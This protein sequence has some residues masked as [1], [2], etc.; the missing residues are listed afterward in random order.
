[1]ERRNKILS[2]FCAVVTLVNTFAGFLIP[3]TTYAKTTVTDDF[4]GSKILLVDKNT[5]G[6]YLT[7]NGEEIQAK[8][9]VYSAEEVARL[10]LL[11]QSYL[12]QK[13]SLEDKIVKYYPSEIE[14]ISKELEL[15]A[16][17]KKVFEESKKKYGDNF[18]SITI[19]DITYYDKEQAG[20]HLLEEVKK[21]MTTDVTHIGNYRGF[22]L[23]IFF[24][25]F[26]NVHKMNIK[27]KYHYQIEL[28]N[29][30]YGNLTRLENAFGN[31]EKEIDKSTIELSNLKEQLENAKLEIRADFKYETELKEKQIRLN[32]VNALLNINEKD[33]NVTTFDDSEEI[34]SKEKTN[35]F[36]RQ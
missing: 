10:K 32:E 29:D 9:V 4:I 1:M 28:G 2:I 16:E 18:P 19:L 24:D 13:Y 27:N 22:E 3:T 6:K 8:F 33:K 30:E 20:K 12:N 25:R 23:E 31:I 34:I 14:R 35:D 5:C 21:I 17:D 15:L 7:Y 36:T 11:K 26:S